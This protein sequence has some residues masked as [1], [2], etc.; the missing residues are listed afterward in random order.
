MSMLHLLQLAQTLDLKTT[1]QAPLPAPHTDFLTSF[2]DQVSAWIPVFLVLFLGL[3]CFVMI[4]VMRAMPRTKPAEFNSESASAVTWDDVAGVEEARAELI[5]IV[6]FLREPERF[7]QLGAKIPRGVILYGPPG[8]GKTLLAKAVAH[9]SG[10]SFYAASASSFVEMFV[11]LG[12]ARIRGLFKD[13]RKNAPSIIFIDELD[14]IGQTRSGMGFNR[15]QDQTLN[16]LLVEMDGFGSRD[17]LVV[18]GA[19]NRLQDLDPA[20]MR[21]GR[22]DRRILVSPPDLQDRVEIL[23]LHA[24][25]KP[26]ASDVDLELVARQTA[27]LTGADLANLVNEAAIFAGRAS[28]QVITHRDF[29]DALERVVAGLE[30]RRIISDKE[31]RILAYHEAGHAVMSHLMGDSPPLQKVTI[32]SRGDALGYTFH[33]PE[34]DRYLHTKEELVDWMTVALGGRAAEQVVFGRVTNGAASDLAKVSSIARVMVFD[35]GM[36]DKINART[37]RA[38]DYPLSEQSKQLRDEEQARLADGAYAEALR[39]L[40]KHRASLDR[41][42]LALLEKETLSRDEMKLL[43]LDVEPESRA[44]ETIGTVRAL[45]DRGARAQEPAS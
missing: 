10:A 9:E 37:V 5:E 21:P 42:A 6:E 40:D 19:S 32:V 33:L 2:R 35:Y 34:E 8:T 13:A 14:A 36:G 22:F 1:P 24:R 41:V 30:R 15:E 27:G 12:A 25:G 16:Q 29:D 44:S 3:M 39:L 11:G 20:L 4:R 26:L 43:L 28:Q 7:N 38:D 45:A 23:R 31:K 18:I 17:Q